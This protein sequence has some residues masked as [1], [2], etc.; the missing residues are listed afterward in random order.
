MNQQS[1]QNAVRMDGRVIVVTGAGRGLGK[2]Y[3]TLM[4]AR[5]ANVVVADNGSAMDGSGGQSSLAA[6]VVE[7]IEAAGGK[8]VACV[9][10]LSTETGATRAIETALDSYGRIDGVLHNASTVPD[11]TSIAEFSTHDLDL[12]MRINA[13][14]A[15]WMSRAAWPHMVKNRFGRILFTTSVGIYGSQGTTPYCAAKAANIGIMRCLADEGRDKGICVN[16]VA[17]SARTRMTERFLDSDYARWFMATMPPEKVGVAVAFLMSESCTVNG[18]VI[19]LG[20]GRVSRMMIGETV[21]R[22]GSGESVEEV[23]DMM[24]DVMADSEYLFPRN[25]AERSVAVAD[26]FGGIGKH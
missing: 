11:L 5:G 16:V 2:S 25:V 22:I 21:G 6:A 18:E 23:R 24:P 13:Y 17:P 12:V 7:E 9:E 14:A 3:C 19:V 1:E 26:L 20:G 15:M 8:A 10:D 4:A